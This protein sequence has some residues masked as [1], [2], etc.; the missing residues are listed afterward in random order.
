MNTGTPLL[1]PSRAA[2]IRARFM[3]CLAFAHLLL[4]AGALHRALSKTVTD[5]ELQVMYAG[6]LA[7]WPVFVIEAIVGV[8]QRDRSQPR[9][10]VIQR[11]I[12]VSLMPPW[13]MALAETRS[14]LIWIPRIGWQRPGKLLF[15]RLER[16]F[17]GPMILFAFLIL[18]LLG[19]EYLQS[20]QLKA[21]PELAL[22]LDIGIA[23]V[24]VAFATEFVFKASVHPKPFRFAKERWLDL[25]IVVLPMLEVFL[26]RVVDAAPIARLL[27]AG[28]ALSPEQLARMQ[29]LY[30]LQ[31][32]ATK[33]WHAF[34]LLEGVNRLLGNTKQKR[35]LRLED[36]IA[37]LEDEMNELRAEADELRAQ[38]AA[39]EPP[40]KP[41][42]TS[43]SP[44]VVDRPAPVP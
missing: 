10:P 29:K 25:A 17:G 33:A 24:W 18:P 4:V 23:V 32:L 15:K 11:A 12:L 36:R 38:I 35:L 1:M 21:M 40:A 43:V 16:A 13:R 41:E 14:G 9:K 31:G 27:R 42:V 28:R 20:D 37:E 7:I 26:T 22:A 8:L 39:E 44:E 6:L 34:L 2:T 5:F 19:M 30:R 3:F